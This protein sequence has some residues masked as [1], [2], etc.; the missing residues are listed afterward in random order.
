MAEELKELTRF[1]RGKGIV[2]FCHQHDLQQPCRSSLGTRMETI[3]FERLYK[4][5]DGGYWLHERF[6]PNAGGHQDT[7]IP[8][9]ES[10]ARAWLKD[11]CGWW[12]RFARLER[13][14]FGDTQSQPARG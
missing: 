7:A 4:A 5:A 3:G 8:L 11:R 6:Y 1:L 13:Q 2:R 10:E 14:V 9:T 12:K